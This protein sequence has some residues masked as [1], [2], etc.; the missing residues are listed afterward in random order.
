MGHHLKA[1]MTGLRIEAAKWPLLEA[2]E[3]VETVAARVGLHDASHLSRLFVR[4]TGTRPGA[5]RRSV[6]PRP[7]FCLVRLAGVEPAT[8]G[9]EVAESCSPTAQ[10]LSVVRRD[11][12]VSRA[13]FATLPHSA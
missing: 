2:D 8:L 5:Y 4:H 1:Y 6:V 13:D 9:L 11:F 12:A 3:K 10:D 7:D